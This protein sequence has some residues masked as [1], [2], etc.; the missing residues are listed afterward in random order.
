[1]TNPSSFLQGFFVP[2]IESKKEISTRKRAY[3]TYDNNTGSDNYMSP[4]VISVLLAPVFLT[5]INILLFCYALFLILLPLVIA[6][7]TADTITRITYLTVFKSPAGTSTT[8]SS[9]TS[10]VVTTYV[11]Q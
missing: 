1:M 4:G 3:K 8:S 11:E 7:A 2:F 5:L 9:L 10:V 6:N